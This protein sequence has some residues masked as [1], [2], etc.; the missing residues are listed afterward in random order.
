MLF[1]KK[2]RR[3]LS[4]ILAT[5]LLTSCAAP[6]KIYLTDKKDG[7]FLSAPRTWHKISQ[8]SLGAQEATSTA[9]GA[10][11]R[12]AS[13]NWQ[14]AVTPS[15]S[16]TAKDV[17][18]LKTPDQP[19]VYVRVRTLLADE[20]NSISYNSLRDLILPVTEWVNGT[21]KAPVFDISNDEEKVEKGGRGVH[22]V[23]DFTQ[24]DGS[25]QTVDQTA[26][27]SNDHSTIYV[28]I[29]RCSTSCYNKQRVALEQIATSF[30]VRGK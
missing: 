14:E 21:V 6:S 13:V 1:T 18:S 4:L 16:Y 23:F 22:T 5:V 19:I 8:L 26:I 29:I 17:L 15:A 3:A 27:L 9:T 7:V 12:A 11:E 28:L 20:V 30:T 2:A 25:S 10:A 24:T